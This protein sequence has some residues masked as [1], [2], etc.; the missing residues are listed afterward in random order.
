MVGLA[1]S[2]TA[3]TTASEDAPPDSKEDQKNLLSVHP[4]QY[5]RSHP[6]GSRVLTINPPTTVTGIEMF[7][8]WV[9]HELTCS[10]TL[11][12]LQVPL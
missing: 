10:P 5:K 2:S 4:G 9:Y 1:R 7:L 6:P 3:S 12:L 11:P 8:F